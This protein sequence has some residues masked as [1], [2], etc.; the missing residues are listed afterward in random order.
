MMQQPTTTVIDAGA[1][2]FAVRYR[3]EVMDDQGISIQV[4][5]NG[6]AKDEEILRFDCFDQHP[7]YHYGPNKVNELIYMDQTTA[8]N[9]VGWTMKQL[10]SHLPDMIKRAGYD[11]VASGLDSYKQATL[12]ATKL[13]EV[14]AAARNSA[15]ADRRTVTHNRGDEMIECG[16]IRF[17]LEFRE[18]EIIN[19]RGLAIHV[20]SDVAGQ[21][22]ELLAFDCFE[23]GPHYHYGPRNK[24]IRLYW[25]TTVTPDP[26]RWTLDQF[27][28]GKLPSMIQR[29]GYPGVVAELDANLVLSKVDNEVEPKALA[30][31]AANTK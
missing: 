31:R 2:K 17:G 20:M 29:A 14:E 6:G 3:Q 24:D 16:N 9:P 23:R 8:G 28:Q 12:I 13:G 21:E 18:L 1:V 5:A 25:D 30:L 26:L 7:H 11:E 10:R 22:I 19:D 15:I 27:K 4:L